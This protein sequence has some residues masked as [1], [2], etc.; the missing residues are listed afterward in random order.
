MFP[1][2]ALS[3]SNGGWLQVNPLFTHTRMYS[4]QH[5]GQL[6]L[7]TVHLR[8]SVWAEKSEV[9]AHLRILVLK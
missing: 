8:G 3:H 2:K 1:A 9:V 6:L 4:P 7:S 5:P